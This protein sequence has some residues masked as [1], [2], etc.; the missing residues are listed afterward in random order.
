MYRDLV[1][2][3]ILTISLSPLSVIY[4]L[5]CLVWL[6]VQQSSTE[7]LREGFLKALMLDDF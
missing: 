1:F 4:R 7:L 3:L 5:P 6:V 2:V